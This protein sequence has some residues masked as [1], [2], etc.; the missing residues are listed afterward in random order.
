MPL[1]RVHPILLCLLF[2]VMQLDHKTFFFSAAAERSNIEENCKSIDIKKPQEF[3][4]F[5]S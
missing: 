1:F 5:E 2:S 4:C 3:F